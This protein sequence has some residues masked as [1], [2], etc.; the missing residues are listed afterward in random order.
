MLTFY[1]TI[2]NLNQESNIKNTI[3]YSTNLQVMAGASLMSFYL[4][5]NN[6]KDHTIH[7]V[8]MCP[9]F[10]PIWYNFCFSVCFINLI[11]FKR[12]GQWNVC[13]FDIF[14]IPLSLHL[15][16]KD[17][18]EVMLCPFSVLYQEVHDSISYYWQ[19]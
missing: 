19:N 14:I 6:N 18:I 2:K 13:Q 9:Y 3:K 4:F 12:A 16:T 8:L 5:Q 1:I 7:F 15:F 11:N 17:N 10:P